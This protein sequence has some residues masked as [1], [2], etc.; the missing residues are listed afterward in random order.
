LLWHRYRQREAS[1]TLAGS[2]L[3]EDPAGIA[4]DIGD[5]IDLFIA[6]REWQHAELTLTLSRFRPGAA[7]ANDKR[8]AAHG[9]EFGVALDF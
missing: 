1:T 8:D 5:E 6:M 3:S 9:I 2:R 7:F 4:R